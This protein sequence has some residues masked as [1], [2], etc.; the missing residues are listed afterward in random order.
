MDG[1]RIEDQSRF[2]EFSYTASCEL[3]ALLDLARAVH[4]TACTIRALGHS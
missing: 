3:L 1:L 4:A 2:T